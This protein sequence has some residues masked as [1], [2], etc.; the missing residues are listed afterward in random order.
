[1][2]CSALIFLSIESPPYVIP[3]PLMDVVYRSRSYAEDYCDYCSLTGVSGK[4]PGYQGKQRREYCTI[5]KHLGY[6]A[7]TAF[8]HLEA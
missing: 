1:M 6:G 8:D 7:F 2:S 4:D 5:G 3:D